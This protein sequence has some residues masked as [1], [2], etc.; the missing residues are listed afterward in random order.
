VY[1]IGASSRPGVAYPGFGV[2]AAQAPT[3]PGRADTLAREIE[4]MYAHFAAEGPTE[5]EITVARRQLAAQVDEQLQRPEF[6]AGR[7]SAV[8]YRGRSPREALEARQEYERIDA[9]QVHDA[10]RRYWRPESRFT[11]LVVPGTG[12]PAPPAVTNN[13][14]APVPMTADVQAP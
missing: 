11:V 14:A 12:T 6:W 2:F 13:R 3:D 5:A 9:G 10:F 4:A 1:S 7:L 8:D